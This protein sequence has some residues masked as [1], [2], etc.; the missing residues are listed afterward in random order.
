MKYDSVSTDVEQVHMQVTSKRGSRTSDCRQLLS[1]RSPLCPP[2][3]LPS[4][5]VSPVRSLSFH[6]YVVML[7][8]CGIPKDYTSLVNRMAR[9]TEVA[10]KCVDLCLRNDRDLV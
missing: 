2:P 1:L 4:L 8:I 6:S 7:L 9:C 10:M 3:V 5:F